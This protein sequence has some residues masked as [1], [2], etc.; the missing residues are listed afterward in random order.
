[1]GLDRHAV[2]PQIIAFGHLRDPARVQFAV[3]FPADENLAVPDNLQ[4]PSRS[5]PRVIAEFAGVNVALWR[6]D[7]PD[8]LAGIRLSRRGFGGVVEQRT[9]TLRFLSALSSVLICLSPT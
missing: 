2:L 3:A 8:F 6:S 4:F 1:V 5:L 9:A 7:A